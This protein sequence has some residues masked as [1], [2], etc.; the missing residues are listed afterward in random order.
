MRTVRSKAR[1]AISSARSRMRCGSRG[2]RDFAD[3]AA[4]RRFIDELV[5]RRNARNR[6]RI[7]A[8]RLMLN[9]LPTR[10]VNDGE[11]AFVTVTSSGGF[12]ARGGCFTPCP[13][14]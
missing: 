11:E 12:M 14:D 1:T 8:E 6:K 13:R 10:R 4:Y 2:S 3:L 7:D 5:G 9:T